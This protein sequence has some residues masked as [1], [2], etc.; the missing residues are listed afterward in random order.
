[1][2]SSIIYDQYTHEKNRKKLKLHSRP[3]H[4]S[5]GPQKSWNNAK[6][7]QKSNLGNNFWHP[8]GSQRSKYINDILIKTDFKSSLAHFTVF[9]SFTNF[10]SRS[11]KGKKKRKCSGLTQQNKTNNQD[12]VVLPKVYLSIRVSGRKI[13][14]N[15]HQNCTED[16]IVKIYKKRLL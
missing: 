16:T 3:Y 1:M 7:R 13:C 2:H 6:Q 12:S 8:Q 9:S 11:I 14:Y 10:W 4:A 15:F 5:N